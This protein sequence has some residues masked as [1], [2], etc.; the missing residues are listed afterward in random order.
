M[1]RL[2]LTVLAAQHPR[3][4]LVY[5]DYGGRVT[6]IVWCAT[7]VDEPRYLK[8]Q[9]RFRLMTRAE[10]TTYRSN[11]CSYCGSTLDKA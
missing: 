7:C 3:A 6:S 8:D 2:T 4:G 5:V 1:D 9:E 11:S 10:Q